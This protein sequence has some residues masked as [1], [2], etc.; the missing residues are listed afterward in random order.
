MDRYFDENHLMIRDMVRDFAENEIAPVAGELDRS[1]EFPWENVK[2]MGELGLF[3]IPWPEEL[4]GAGMDGIAYMIVIHE[5]ARVDASHAITVSAHTTLGS[6]P[7][8]NFGTPEQKER[9]IPLLASGTVL[10]GFGLTE[11][12]AGSDAGGTQTT[13]TK[14]DGGWILNGSKIFITHAGVGEIFVVTAQ[15]D[16]EKGTKGI[17]SFIVSKPTTDLEKAREIGIGHAQDGQ[18]C[19]TEGV[20]AGKKEDKMGWRAS[21]TRELVLENAFVPDKNVL[22]EVGMGFVNFMKTLDAGRIGIG[23]LSLGL[24]EGA[25]EQA[26]AYALERQQFGKPIADFQGIQFMLA[27]MATEIE[28]AKHLVYHAAWLKEQGRPYTREASM[29]KLFASETAM[30]VTTRAVQ[31]HGGYGYTR[32]YPVERM[33]RDAKI[34]EIGEG[35]SEIQRLV[36][37]RSLLR[38]LAH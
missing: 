1:G 27:D 25:F 7:I 22:G 24:A 21:D 3:G 30:R 35:T 11:P 31:V 9:F 8:V 28:A 17:T 14:V 32:E 37:A 12:G 26:R 23:A 34:C 6:S 18:L 13:A 33:M 5:L 10:G 29:A 15:T 36:I 4:G 38:E 2:K 19:Y 16:K 20:R